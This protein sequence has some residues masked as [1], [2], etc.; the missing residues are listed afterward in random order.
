VCVGDYRL[1]RL[2]RSQAKI[3]ILGIAVQ[4]IVPSDPNRV[5]LIIVPSAALDAII[6]TDDIT[7]TTA[8]GWLINATSR[9]ILSVIEHGDLPTKRWSGKEGTPLA[10]ATLLV[11]EQFLPPAVLNIPLEAIQTPIRYP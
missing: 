4:E 7:V 5:G 8:N 1:G 3:V 6:G 11:I 10:G 9:F 2:V